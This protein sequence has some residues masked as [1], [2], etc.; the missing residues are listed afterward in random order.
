MFVER[1]LKTYVTLNSNEVGEA[2]QDFIYKQHPKLKNSRMYEA[3]MRLIDLKQ[4]PEGMS[5]L[6]MVFT[7]GIKD[8]EDIE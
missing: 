7:R 3:F 4:H 1:R 8:D 6:T 5:P 2:C